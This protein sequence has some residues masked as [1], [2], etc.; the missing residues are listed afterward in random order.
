MNHSCGGG[1]PRCGT[2]FSD[3]TV[4]TPTDDLNVT[5]VPRPSRNGTT[6]QNTAYY[7][8]GRYTL[9]VDVVDGVRCF[10]QALPSHD[11]YSWDAMSLQGTVTSTFETGCFG[12]PG[13]T[14]VFNFALEPM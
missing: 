12:A 2:P 3:P 5:A 11:V 13:G 9:S 6:F 8:D 14:N 10:G 7:A 1:D 4:T